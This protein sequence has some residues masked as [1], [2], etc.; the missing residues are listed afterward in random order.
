MNGNGQQ[1]VPHPVSK[2]WK[3]CWQHEPVHHNVN[4]D[5]V[6][7]TGHNRVNGQ[8]FD[9]PAGQVK[10]RHDYK[11]HEKMERQAEAS[12]YQSAVEGVSAQQSSGDSLQPVAR[13]YAALPPDHERGRNV[14]NTDDQTGSENCAKR[15]GVFHTI[16]AELTQE[17]K[18]LGSKETIAATM[19]QLMQIRK[20]ALQRMRATGQ[21]FKYVT[22]ITS[23][24]TLDRDF[25]ALEISSLFL[26]SWIPDLLLALGRNAFAHSNSNRSP[27]L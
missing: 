27:D 2:R 4:A 10:N 21:T 22:L 17:S 24:G 11:R 15:P 18:K 5:P 19:H 7:H 25:L 12:R 13:T 9:L 20:S 23:A 8:K 3:R 26:F 14:Q 1:L 6:Q 16:S